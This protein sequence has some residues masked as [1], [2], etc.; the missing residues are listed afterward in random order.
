M[1]A[2]QGTRGMLADDPPH[3]DVGTEGGEP[4]SM[5]LR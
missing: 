1:G 2:T 3:M 4:T 5:I